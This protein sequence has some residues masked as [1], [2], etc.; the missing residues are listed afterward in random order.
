M[1]D[2]KSQFINLSMI[3]VSKDTDKKQSFDYL[4]WAAAW[5][6][7]KEFDENATVSEQ[8][9]DYCE[10]ISGQHQD[11]LITKKVP[12]QMV[13]DSSYVTVTVTVKGKTETEIFAVTNYSNKDVSKPAMTQVNKALKRA[14]VKALAKH[15]LGLM[16]YLGEDV[17]T[18]PRISIRDLDKLDVAVDKLANLLGQ[19]VDEKLMDSLV[20]RTNKIIV[21]DFNYLQTIEKLEEM[22]DDQLGLLLKTIQ[23]GQKSLEDK[24]KE[25]Q[26][27]KKNCKA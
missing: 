24:A 21:Q 27:S 17:P 20:A 10:V 12:F 11:F 23:K 14:F 2:E 16:V 9:F 22:N 13:N 26:K 1:S 3:D 8:T 25:E 6:Y 4:P 18:I 19:A 5:R 15:G 7:M